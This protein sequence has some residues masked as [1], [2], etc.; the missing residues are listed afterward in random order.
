VWKELIFQDKKGKKIITKN[1]HK[2]II[3]FIPFE[4]SLVTIIEYEMIELVRE[5]LIN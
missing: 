5:V 1:K 3:L 2:L 4:S